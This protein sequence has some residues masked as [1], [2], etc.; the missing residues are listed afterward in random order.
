V[1]FSDV[2]RRDGSVVHNALHTLAN[3]DLL[4]VGGVNDSVRVSKTLRYIRQTTADMGVNVDS[5]VFEDYFLENKT[6]VADQDKLN[7]KI[8]ALEEL[9]HIEL[10]GEQRQRIID[11]AK[12]NN[13]KDR[14]AAKLQ[15]VNH[16]YQN[17]TRALEELARNRHRI[18]R[19]FQQQEVAPIELVKI[20]N[21]VAS[22][23]FWRLKDVYCEDHSMVITWET[24]APITLVEQLPK[25]GIERSVTLGNFRAALTYPELY[26]RI[27]RSSKRNI[28]GSSHWGNCI[29]PHIHPNDGICWGE[30]ED[31]VNDAKQSS[32][33]RELMLLLAR[34][35]SNYNGDSPYATLLAFEKNAAKSAEKDDA[36][37]KKSFNAEAPAGGVLNELVNDGMLK[38]DMVP[39]KRQGLYQPMDLGLGAADVLQPIPVAQVQAEA[40]A[41]PGI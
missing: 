27:E 25:A 24:N 14:M 26:I 10:G 19:D 17:Y 7:K 1:K 31:Q 13:S 15:E 39:N 38:M 20:I 23:A 34:N 30:L 9:K 32:D 5:V 18:L 8:F 29:H 28:L 3:K 16:K 35:L 41:E 40:D 4:V 36:Q 12:I 33:V 2:V 6:V 21:S 22:D 37:M 11:F